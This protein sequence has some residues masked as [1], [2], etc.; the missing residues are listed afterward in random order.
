M[1]PAEAEA[2]AART[3]A[4]IAYWENRGDNPD[5]H[6]ADRE[7]VASDLAGLRSHLASTV[8]EDDWWC[9]FCREGDCED[10][11]RYAASLR[12]TAALYG[13]TE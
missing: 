2:L 10:A 4:E 6:I 12:R 5:P 13:V 7:R 8:E 9:W 3:L 1:T 11:P